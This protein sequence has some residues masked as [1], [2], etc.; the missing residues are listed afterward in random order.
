MAEE[1]I[2]AILDDIPD[3]DETQETV[4]VA[5]VVEEVVE[6]VTQEEIEETESQV[7]KLFET[8]HSGQ[9]VP[10][11]KHTALRKRAQ[12]AEAE[13]DALKQQLAQKP[14]DDTSALDEL[15]ALAN[16]E[17]EEYIEGKQ[18]KEV[19]S[20][21][22]NAIAQIAQ[23]TTQD[24]IGRIASQNMANKAASDEASFKKDHP[25]Y[26]AKV[27]FAAQ[28]QLLTQADLQE[29]FS[30]GNIAEAYYN[31]ANAAIE[32]EKVALGIPS[33]PSTKEKPSNEPV[34]DEEFASEE[35]AFDF[36]IDQGS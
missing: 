21:L 36:M 2:D 26:D 29:V 30:S 13:R 33:S 28:R 8:D 1:G 17:D 18:L 25:D 15:N 7:A 16:V 20:K 34:D 11:D 32:A 19:V 3:E 10:L 24:A 35:D 14:T 31:K 9:T 4:E 23:K 22:P 6:E 5:E 12:G 27:A